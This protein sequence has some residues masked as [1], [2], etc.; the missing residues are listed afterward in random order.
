MRIN[1]AESRYIAALM[2]SFGTTDAMFYAKTALVNRGVSVLRFNA[3]DSIAYDRHFAIEKAAA[4]ASK[5]RKVT[6]SPT[7]A[8]AG[9]ARKVKYP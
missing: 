4:D 1:K 8:R 3:L 5:P 6:K 9:S 2:Q 7:K